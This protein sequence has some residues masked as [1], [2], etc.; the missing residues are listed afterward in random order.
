MNN[1]GLI[2]IRLWSRTLNL[3]NSFKHLLLGQILEDIKSLST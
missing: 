1:L 3:Y 2:Y